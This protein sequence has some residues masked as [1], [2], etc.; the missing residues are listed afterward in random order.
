M[1]L[2]NSKKKAGIIAIAL[3]T[4]ISAFFIF[5]HIA[6]GQT[7]TSSSGTATEE[8]PVEDTSEL[9]AAQAERAKLIDELA[10]LEK[11]IIAKQ[12]ELSNQKGQSASI[13]N[14]IKII[15]TQISEAKL[16][17]KSR[18]LTI[19]SLSKDISKKARTIDNLEEKLDKEK[20]SLSQMIRQTYHI[21][22]TPFVYVALGN[23][24]VSEFYRDLDSF[25]TLKRS[26]KVSL[27]QVRDIKSDTEAEKKTL[28]KKHD[29]ELDVKYE[30]ESVKKTI[31]RSEKE[32]QKLLSVSKTK[33]S[34]LSTIIAE[35]QAKVD[36]IKA[37]LFRFA[38]GTK[39]IR[40]EYALQYAQEASGKTSIEPSFVLA[41]LTQESNL[42]SN[43]GRCYLKDPATG[44]GVNVSSA[45][46]YPNVMKPSRD[47]TPFLSIT[48]ALGFDPY[49][50]AVSCPI[51]GAGGYGGAM[52]PAQ[53]IASTWK[54]IEGRIESA[55]GISTAN[56]W[57]AED[58]IMASA[59]Y[60]SDLGG[61]GTS[62]ASQM[63]AAC[64]YYGTG[65]STCA[66]GRSVMKLKTAIQSDIDYLNE[67][68]VSRR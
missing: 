52:G 48:S 60:L 47:V 31:E 56:P 32:K 11:E 5:Q 23:E 8:Q 10:G 42:G 18:T 67:Y 58:A 21:D 22:Q 54:S 40:F 39:S 24:S 6:Q 2:N 15:N 45:K 3:S 36:Q 35:R 20:E 68:G 13:S 59:I 12:K 28:E 61:G 4:F 25:E 9:S 50:T 41:I 62:S 55:R 66:Y 17:I 29:Q 33:E 37:K 64:K 16:K 43:V 34:A 26:V 19:A 1:L 14:E 46:T 38:G 44:A 30:L 63:R 27:D 53:F 57:D 51:A 7:D 65:G 49:N